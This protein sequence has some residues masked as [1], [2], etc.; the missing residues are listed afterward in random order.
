MNSITQCITQCIYPP[1]SFPL[2]SLFVTVARLSFLLLS[3]CIA[4]G[5]WTEHSWAVDC[6]VRANFDSLE[7]QQEQ[8]AGHNS[9]S[10]R[11]SSS[12]SS[13]CKDLL[14]SCHGWFEFTV[15]HKQVFVSLC[16]CPRLVSGNTRRTTFAHADTQ[17]YTHAETHQTCAK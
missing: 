4:L 11:S 12:S 8:Q 2:P 10:R 3:S 9:R 15:E 7:Q 1:Y 6:S 14:V 5:Q 17:R 13:S 16:Q